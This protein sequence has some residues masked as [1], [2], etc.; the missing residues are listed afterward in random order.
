MA[1]IVLENTN[2]ATRA[3]GINRIGMYGVSTQGV[4]RDT[5]R[6]KNVVTGKLNKSVVKEVDGKRVN[7]ISSNTVKATTKA[8]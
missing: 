5:I 7:T 8:A 4:K 1:R 6:E 2:I 3:S